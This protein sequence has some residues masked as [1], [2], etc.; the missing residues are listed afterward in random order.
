MTELSHRATRTVDQRPEV[1]HDRLL[2]L[3]ERLRTELPPIKPDT[4]AASALGVTGSIGLEIRDRGPNRIELLTTRGRVRGHGA[5]DLAATGDGQTTVTV[6]LAV[7]PDGFAGNLML[8]VALRTMPNL[9][10]DVIQ[11][12]EAGMDDLA[13][14]LAKP[15]DEWDASSWQPPGVPARG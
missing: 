7:K 11:G 10:R 1:V 8:G 15:D 14:E 4:R 9:E 2:E 3:A 5:V 13:V 6:A 12:L